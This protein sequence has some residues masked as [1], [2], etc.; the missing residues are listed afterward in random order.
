MTAS[1]DRDAL[2]RLNEALVEDI[3]GASDEAL[4]AEV[5]QD[6]QD[7]E[8]IAAAARTL[9]EKAVLRASK[10]RLLRAQAAVAA[11]RRAHSQ[12]AVPDDPAAA[13]RRLER[14]LARHPD[15]ARKLTL[16]ARKGQSGELS[17]E[18]VCG[19]LEDFEELGITD[20]DPA[21]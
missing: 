2:Q 18:E 8:R 19:W 11:D 15:A 13:R 1:D 3:L 7:P 12:A 6:G 16:A 10:L 4:L 17:D 5:R 9:F 14:L 21:C 20:A